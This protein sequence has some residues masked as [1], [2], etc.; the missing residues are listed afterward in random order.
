MSGRKGA[1]PQAV[2]AQL[3]HERV[4]RPDR[5][6]LGHPVIEELRQ[7]HPLP[8]ILARNEPFH[9]QPHGYVDDRI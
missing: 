6:L 7:Q 1:E 9:R 4:N 2:M 8:P 5:V 3:I